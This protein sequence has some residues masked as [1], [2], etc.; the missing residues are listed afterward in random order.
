MNHSQNDPHITV[1]AKITATTIPI[2]APSL[3]LE[4]WL[5]V[6]SDGAAEGFERAT[7]SAQA[8]LSNDVAPFSAAKPWRYVVQLPCPTFC[9]K[10]STIISYT[11]D[12]SVNPAIFWDNWKL[13]VTAAPA[14]DAEL[15]SYTEPPTNPFA[16]DDASVTSFMLILVYS[17]PFPQQSAI[18]CWK[19]NCTKG[20]AFHM[21]E[22][23]PL[24]TYIRRP[25]DEPHFSKNNSW[26]ITWINDATTAT[27]PVGDGVGEPAAKVGDLL[28]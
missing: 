14:V 4:L 20:F 24:N 8:T 21:V 2:I 22:L 11:V 5:F 23:I 10:L 25:H 3:N 15:P 27:D 16:D 6:D 1:S 7:L 12:S 19:V 18:V 26:S 9:I 28:G 13:I 17:T